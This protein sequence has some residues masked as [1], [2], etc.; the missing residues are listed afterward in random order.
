ML[1]DSFTAPRVSQGRMNYVNL[2][3]IFVYIWEQSGRKCQQTLLGSCVHSS[4]SMK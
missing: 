4:V 1:C 3:T 2:K